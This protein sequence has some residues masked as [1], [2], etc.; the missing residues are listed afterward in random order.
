MNMLERN[1][2]KTIKSGSVAKALIRQGVSPKN[3]MLA[4]KAAVPYC[5]ITMNAVYTYRSDVRRED[6]CLPGDK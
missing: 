4:T 1:D 6:G 3:V 5:D 2:T